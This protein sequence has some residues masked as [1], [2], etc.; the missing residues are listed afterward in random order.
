MKRSYLL[1]K[2]N[3]YC[4]YHI[5]KSVIYKVVRGCGGGVLDVLAVVIFLTSMSNNKKGGSAN[6]LGMSAKRGK[7]SVRSEASLRVMKMA[8]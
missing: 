6:P 3:M 2:I 8:G 5:N 7:P 1:M 4:N